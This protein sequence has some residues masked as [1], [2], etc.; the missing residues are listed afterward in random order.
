MSHSCLG[1]RRY[2]VVTA[3]AWW[4]ISVSQSLANDDF[5][6]S[7]VN[8]V[9]QNG[10]NWLDGTTPQGGDAAFF[11]LAGA[12]TVSFNGTPFPIQALT[13]TNATNA[14]FTS[15]SILNVG[16]LQITSASGNQNVIVTDSATLTLGTSGGIFNPDRPLHLTVGNDLNVQNGARLNVR[17]GSDV[18]TH[19]LNVA[20]GGQVNVIGSG[21]VLTNDS[22]LTVGTAV[23]GVAAM[24][25]QNGGAVFNNVSYVGGAAESPGIV[26][27][28]GAGSTWLNI[29]WIVVGAGVGQM[30]I[31]DA[32]S[33]TSSTGQLGWLAGSNGSVSVSGAGSAWTMSDFLRV[34]ESGAGQLTI[35]AGG[36]VSNVLGV[37][38]LNPG[39][40]GAATV[41][42]AGSTWTN[43]GELTIGNS[44]VGTLKIE[45]GGDVSNTDGYIGRVAGSTGLVNVAG[46]GSTWTN[47]GNVHVGWGLNAT[48]N[49]L[50]I[51]GGGSV[52][53]NAAFIATSAGS[54]GTATV[55]GIGSTWTNEQ[56]MVGNLGHGTL[57][58]ENGGHVS[59]NFS[60]IASGSSSSLS[61]GDAI[62]TGPGSV[63][64]ANG[65]FVVG[66]LGIATLSIE[67]GGDVTTNVA[68]IIGSG[69][70]STGIVTV[71]G[72]GS[73][74]TISGSLDVGSMGRGT[75]NIQNGAA[76]SNTHASIAR[77]AGSNGNVTVS[78]AGSTWSNTGRLGVGGNA[79]LGTAGGTGTL[80]IGPGGT[81]NANVDVVVFPQGIARLQ[82]GALDTPAVRFQGGGGQFQWTSGT[83]H[84]GTFDGN[85]LNQGGK[86]APGHSAG[87]TTIVGN[88]T[89]QFAAKLE[90][91]IGGAAAFDTDIVNVTG[92]AA[93]NGQLQLALINGFEPSAAQVFS[94]MQAGGLSG[95][96]NNVANGQR[97]V[98]NGGAGSFIVNYG[99]GSAFPNQVRLTDFQPTPT[100]LV[101]YEPFDYSPAGADLEGKNG[102]SGFAGP[103]AGNGIDPA[104]RFNIAPDSLSFGE[105]RTAGNR[106]TT[107][108]SVSA[109]GGIARELSVP[110]G[111]PGTTSYLSFIMR[112]EDTL[113]QG[114]FNGF[115]GLY[116]NAST[117][118]ELFV[119]KP[120]GGALDEWVLEDLGG[121][122][123]HASGVEVVVDEGFLHVIRADFNDGNDVF[124]L[125]VN[126]TPGAAEPLSGTIKNDSDVGIVR[127]L[128]L[129][130]SGAFSIDELRIGT[131]YADVV[132]VS[133]VLP[134]DYNQN[135]V[136]DAADYVVWRDNEGTS[137]DLPND[138]IG[139]MIGQA[140]YDQWR[141]HFGQTS[142]SGSALTPAETTS[143]NV[144]EPATW[145][146]L[147]LAAVGIFVK[148]RRDIAFV[149]KLIRA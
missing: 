83:L 134:G 55:T 52:S 58:V 29:A 87:T 126:P 133:I 3:A 19:R 49:T 101:A 78:G 86:L 80:N 16:T 94:V 135:G 7:A 63:W 15:A 68:G 17:F 88:Y 61:V 11:N 44:G 95:A 98:I 85:L 50:M 109:S 125:Y 70:S 57:M 131:S 33:V 67:A 117:G 2:V 84:V 105:L 128:W 99:P 10:T 90:I 65:I 24:T 64:T 102:G 106:A 6:A 18:T 20:S 146:L 9:W 116:L 46:A 8:G 111:A 60:G 43:S 136:V 130:A 21:S 62:V 139:G 39:S 140:H 4:L 77:N 32:G 75:L 35:S 121:A 113:H 27:V 31:Q 124:T 143:A 30:I 59:S 96:F 23:A 26:T 41:T 82:G 69:S 1:I 129:W 107:D 118:D 148:R 127:S 36:N 71:T 97:L 147:V 37:M 25:I 115:F 45:S 48:G 108:A 112:P 144:P 42:G 14:N 119:G 89:Q 123:Q 5:W 51:E 79:V 74:W 54:I 100:G 72:I 81:V 92:Q 76:V 47:H 120:G 142:G 73:A 103:W 53:N 132:P 66:G 122:Q 149:S 141:A 56:L 28:T 40:S 22:F 138:E 137:N 145:V 38:G 110:L 114:L 93:L 34:G 12:Y 13:V 91:E 104:D